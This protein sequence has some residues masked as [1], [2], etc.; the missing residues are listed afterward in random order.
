[1]VTSVMGGGSVLVRW[2]VEASEK[3]MFEWHQRNELHT[4]KVQKQTYECG[5][6]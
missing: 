3:V 2:L 1:M 4:R 6:E 5:M